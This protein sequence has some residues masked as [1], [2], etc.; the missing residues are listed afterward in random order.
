MAALKRSKDA[1][2]RDGARELATRPDD[3]PGGAAEVASMLA[4]SGSAIPRRPILEVFVNLLAMTV[5]MG[6]TK[7]A[8]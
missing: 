5:Q 7:G 1:R 3:R 6:D 2:R 8:V 4:K